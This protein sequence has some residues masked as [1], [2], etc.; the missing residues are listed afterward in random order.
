MTTIEELNNFLFIDKIVRTEEQLQCRLKE[1]ELFSTGNKW[2]IYAWHGSEFFNIPPP[3]THCRFNDTLALPYHQSNMRPDGAHD[4]ARGHRYSTLLP[5]V[6]KQRAILAALGVNKKLEGVW[7]SEGAFF[8]HCMRH[9]ENKRT[10]P[11]T[12]EGRLYGIVGG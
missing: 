9:L 3:A 5:P 8:G 4:Y 7:A 12:F 10:R 6:E 11:G 1:I 2:N